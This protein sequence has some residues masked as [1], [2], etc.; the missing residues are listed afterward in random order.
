ML[1]DEFEE[2]LE[3]LALAKTIR[4]AQA[5]RIAAMHML[6]SGRLRTLFIFNDI[7]GSEI[8]GLLVTTVW[9]LALS[10][11]AQFM[12][13]LPIYQQLLAEG[14]GTFWASC[15]WIIVATKFVALTTGNIFIRRIA[16]GFG[17]VAWFATAAV[18]F[19]E[20]NYNVLV[21]LPVAFAISA[22]WDYA[23]TSLELD[24]RAYRISDDTER[25][26]GYAP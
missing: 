25:T 11:P 2:Q 14:S 6:P 26:E 7:G 17:L 10:I 12:V 19:F 13:G 16:Y 1:N 18:I 20:G 9:A 3:L 22:W 5:P 24:Q 4:D 21:G 23:R 15:W 8:V